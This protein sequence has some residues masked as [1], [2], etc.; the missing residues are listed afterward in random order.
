M[1]IASGC[2][3]GRGLTTSKTATLLE[4]WLGERIAW[5]ATKTEIERRQRSRDETI[6][7]LEGRLGDGKS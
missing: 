2:R 3:D 7:L 1:R 4:E 5:R 6:K